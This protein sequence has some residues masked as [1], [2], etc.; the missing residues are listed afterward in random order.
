MNDFEEF[1]KDLE[2]HQTALLQFLRKA[3]DEAIKSN[4]E[5]LLQIIQREKNIVTDGL[6]SLAKKSK[7]FYPALQ[8]ALSKRTVRLEKQIEELIKIKDAL[9]SDNLLLEYK[10][11]ELLLLTQKL[12]EAYDEISAKNQEL[13]NQQK[14]IQHQSQD[15]NRIHQEILD[16]NAELEQQKEALLDQSDY[17]HEANER[18]TQ[19]HEQVQKQKDEILQKNEELTQLNNE[20]NNLISIVAHDLKS[21]L[22]QMK[23]LLSIIKLT[24]NLDQETL[25]YINMMEG[26]TKRLTDMIGKILDVEVI[27]AK[28]VNVMMEQVNVSEM[29]RILKE[30]YLFTA[31][32]KNLTLHLEVSD[33][34]VINADKTYTEQ[35]F[36]NLLSNAIKFSPS[37]K[38]IF[39]NATV[40]NGMAIIEV[41]D[42]GPGISDEDKK[43]LFGKYQKLT[44]KPTGN[45]TSTGLGLSIVKKFVDAM[46]GEIW[47]ESEAGYG[48]SFF[49]KFPA[50]RA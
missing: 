37:Y 42:E 1:E 26:S 34:I 14:Q 16:K 32:Q 22:N 12:E 38:R 36:E 46:H 30:R 44:A 33:N 9:I 7:N 20:K 8:K 29:L 43:K 5:R 10:K 19:M 47:C 41:R 49:V 48:A 24:S 18:I 2:R 6:F 40:E 45:E 13:I 11:K 23:G 3:E 21:P 4:D 17:L 35:I 39:I 50:H 31:Q 15:L 25:Q 27:D 28:T